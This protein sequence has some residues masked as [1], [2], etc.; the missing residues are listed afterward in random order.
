MFEKDYLMKLLGDLIQAMV[1]SMLYSTKD[2]NPYMAARSLENAIGAAVDMDSE[3]FLSMTPE[4]MTMM[5][6]ISPLDKQGSEYIARS[7]ALASVYNREAGDERLAELRM[8]QAKAVAGSFGIDLDDMDF[9][10]GTTSTEANEIMTA[11]IE[12]DGL[13]E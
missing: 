4:S 10:D 2:E 11:H 5:M 3:L 7:L 13:S 1:R 12:A 8:Q 9:D 6:E